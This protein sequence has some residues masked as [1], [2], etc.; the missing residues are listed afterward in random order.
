MV[1]K[2]LYIRQ[3][4][5]QWSLREKKQRS[6]NKDCSSLLPWAFSL[7]QHMEGTS[8]GADGI[9]KFRVRAE[10]LRRSRQLEFYWGPERRKVESERNPEVIK[11]PPSL[12]TTCVWVQ[13]KYVKRAERT[14]PS[15]WTQVVIVPVGSSRL[16][17]L[18]IHLG[19][20]VRTQEGIFS[21]VGVI[22]PIGSTA[23][24]PSNKSY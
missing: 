8:A 14:L 5:G 24:I 13:G 19:H 22:S 10:C 4:E 18:R 6:V 15:T 11:E 20:L 2:S 17:N 9:L 23:L 12:F 21:V 7:Q 16:E 1:G 3:C